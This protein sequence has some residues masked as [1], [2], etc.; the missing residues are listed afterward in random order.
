MAT[1]KHTVATPNGDPLTR[2]FQWTGL[3][4]GDDGSPIGAEWSAYSDRSVQVSG[5]FDTAT[6]TWEGSNEG[7]TFATLNAPQ[8][9]A[10]SF[11][12]AGLRQILESAQMQRP[13]V[14][15]GTAPSIT[16][17]VFARRANH[18]RS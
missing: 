15:G 8:G 10:L 5:S 3:A 9:T 6:V 16:V 13:K 11:T 14:T 18:G 17:T 12:A 7:S 2:V 1:I 4:A